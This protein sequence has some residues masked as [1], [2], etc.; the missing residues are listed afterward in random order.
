M[1]T[2]EYLDQSL[3]YLLG[4]YDALQ[5]SIAQDIARRLV[6]TG[7]ITETAKWQAKR[8]QAAG[9]LLTGVV[10]KVAVVSGYSQEEVRRLFTEAGIIGM[11]NDA[12]PL[13]KAGYDIDLTLSPDMSRQLE[14]AIAKTCGDMR[15][16]TMTTGTTV[17]GQY[18]EASNL[19][20]M[21]VTSGGFSYYEAIASAIR[22][23]AI[24]GN[25][26]NYASGARSR[27]DVAIRRS[28]L[29]G[30]NQTAGKLTE[31]YA[32]DMGAEYYE[33]SA[34]S[35]ARPA[36]AEWQGRV[37]KINGSAPG[38]PNFYEATGYGTGAGLCGWNCRHSFYPYWPGISTPAYTSEKLEWYNAARFSYDGRRLTD[39]QCSQIQRAFERDIR[40][41]KRVLA[42]YDA[43]IKES[44]K[45]L[46]SVFLKE[47]FASE[48]VKLKEAE[49]RMKDFC[50]QTRRRPDSKRT[51]VVAHMDGNGRI[52][53]FG[54]STA[55]KARYGAE[56]RFQQTI[57]GTGANIGGPAT[58][59]E[60]NRLR[61]SNKQESQLYDLYLRQV[62]K[63]TVSP[64][65]TFGNY[66]E[67]YRSIE[68][69]IVGMT[70][71]GGTIIK[72]QSKHFIERIIG[73]SEDP[74]TERP[75]SGVSVSDA[76]DALANPL[77]IKDKTVDKS[78]NASI[79]YIGKV[80]TVSIN[81]D[82]GA[83]IQCN[84]TRAKMRDG[85]LERQV[86]NG[87]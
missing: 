23:A 9:S 38:Y 19:A 32:R 27:L 74:K 64:L 60:R 6:K 7:T 71:S 2:P 63:G 15:N 59:A 30:M 76:V 53:N 29:T 1:L 17:V 20:Y 58:L 10:E 48:S 51:Q 31:L 84:P 3:D 54:R 73:T 37:F 75:R 67:Q 16:L 70:A 18:M 69:N 4:M 49:A 45:S 11:K 86:K 61:Y 21:K 24:D 80:A 79:K 66:K 78:G 39:Y 85:L 13:I 26:V 50:K 77:K 47:Q 55:Q 81:P 43:A 25:F 22:Q 36:H 44:P 28:V 42:S 46:T 72:S 33:T 52:V 12:Q 87:D 83:L 82:T 62:K 14:A 40:A 57:S 68:Q 41:L 8:A 34:H 5:T 65:C 56:R 35:G